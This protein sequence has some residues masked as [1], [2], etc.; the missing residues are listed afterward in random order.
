MVTTTCIAYHYMYRQ[1][2]HVLHTNTCIC[3]Q[4]MHWQPVH[5]LVTNESLYALIHVWTRPWRPASPRKQHAPREELKRSAQHANAIARWVE[6]ALWLRAYM[7]WVV[8]VFDLCFSSWIK[9]LFD[10]L[11]WC[12][13]CICLHILS[14]I[15]FM[16]VTNSINWWKYSVCISFV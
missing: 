7:Y 2:I 4:Y 1:A 8:H 6:H 9:Y 10:A 15:P 5:V 16:Y 11:A 12:I 13:W 3:N 14:I